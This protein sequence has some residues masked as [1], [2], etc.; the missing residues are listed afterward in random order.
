[1]ILTSPENMDLENW[2]GAI[3]VD[4]LPVVVPVYTTTW[5]DWVD[6]LDNTSPIPFI[7]SPSSILYK[8]DEWRKWAYD[9]ISNLVAWDI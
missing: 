6:D 7:P 5:Q 2:I 3:T 1:M 8:E 9:F 4:L